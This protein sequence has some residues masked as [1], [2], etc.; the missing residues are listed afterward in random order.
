MMKSRTQGCYAIC[1][2]L[3]GLML[4][5]CSATAPPG[6]HGDYAGAVRDLIGAAS[7]A[8]N[9][10]VY[11]AGKGGAVGQAE[12]DRL[13]SFIAGIYTN[14]P[15]SLRVALRGPASA[16]RFK[17]V[18]DLL[19]ADGVDPR[20][21]QRADPHLVPPAPAGTVAVLVERAIA[22]Q[23]ACPGWFAN[24]SAPEDNRTNS[25]FGCSDVSNFAAMIG[26]PHELR[27]GDASIYH[28]GER[29]ANS[30]SLYRADKVKDLPALNE[31]FTVIPTAH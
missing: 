29:G 18:A 26:D 12:R 10:V 17:V 20:N 22:I 7:V 3:L 8:D 13:A 1:L 27:V 24:V 23:P 2:A 31:T 9:H 30:I 5:G 6:I 28:D 11:F 14:R 21:I 19:V 16:A 15:E 4:A 25:N